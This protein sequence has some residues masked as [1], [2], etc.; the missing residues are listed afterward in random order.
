MS[1]EGSFKTFSF[2]L[3]VLSIPPAFVLSQDQTL[4]K[5]FIVSLSASWSGSFDDF[6]K[7]SSHLRFYPLLI[8]ISWNFRFYGTILFSMTFFSFDNHSIAALP[9]FSCS[10]TC[11]GMLPH[12]SKRAPCTLLIL[13]RKFKVFVRLSQA[14]FF[15]IPRHFRSVKHFLKFIF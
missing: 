1:P 14:N 7:C 6:L 11:I 10:V 3:H 2:D 8:L 15:I 12:A 5:K 13:F 9:V 4:N